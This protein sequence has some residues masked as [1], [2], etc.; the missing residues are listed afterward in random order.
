MRISAKRLLPIYTQEMLKLSIFRSYTPELAKGHIS[1]RNYRRLYSLPTDYKST[2]YG[3]HIRAEAMFAVV[4]RVPPRITHYVS[5]S[6]PVLIT[7]LEARQSGAGV[8]NAFRQ[9]GSSK[10]VD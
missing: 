8:A 2:Y 3:A 9:S 1:N 7:G 10:A 5:R 6:V 4:S